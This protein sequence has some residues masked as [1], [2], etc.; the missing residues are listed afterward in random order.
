MQ[1]YVGY[2]TD[3]MR[4]PRQA[5]DKDRNGCSWRGER[6][7]VSVSVS[8][9]AGWVAEREAGRGQCDPFDSA[10]NASIFYDAICVL[11]VMNILPRQ[12]RANI[13]KALQKEGDHFSQ[14][15]DPFDSGDD[16]IAKWGYVTDAN[17]TVPYL[18]RSILV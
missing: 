17:G 13:G 1:I 18:L 8:A 6:G 15:G 3:R 16:M 12:A 7:G 11:K 2:A 4:L 14:V 5:R 9:G 10:K